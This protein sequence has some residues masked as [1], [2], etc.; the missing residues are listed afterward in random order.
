MVLCQGR[1]ASRAGLGGGTQAT[2]QCR[3][4]FSNRPC[5]EKRHGQVGAGYQGQGFV[6]RSSCSNGPGSSPPLPRP[7]SRASAHYQGCT[8]GCASTAGDWD[9]ARANRSSRTSSRRKKRRD[10]DDLDDDLPR[11]KRRDEDDLDDDRP[12]LSTGAKIL[13]IAGAAVLLFVLV[14][15]TGFIVLRPAPGAVAEKRPESRNDDEQL[16]K[17][18]I[19]N[20]SK[21]PKEVQ[22]VSWGPHMLNREVQ[23]LRNAGAT[24]FP[25][26]RRSGDSFWT[27]FNDEYR[28]DKAGQKGN[29]P[30]LSFIRVRFHPP[31]LDFHFREF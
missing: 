12:C 18:F 3:S 20:N 14:G 16:V 8:N 30:S 22:F 15:I 24:Q 25:V 7:G 27:K 11:K 31:E 2:G 23:E 29:V 13:I 4:T 6:F 1:E 9:A 10:D 19:L 17:Q 21:D 26:S 28:G 5:L